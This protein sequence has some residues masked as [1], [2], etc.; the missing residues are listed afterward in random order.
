ML[1]YKA[2]VAAC[3]GIRGLMASVNILGRSI[4]GNSF[5]EGALV[6]VA[7]MVILSAPV[8]NGMLLCT[9]VNFAIY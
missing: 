9:L 7:V 5:L 8:S 6:C 2:V 3:S 1:S 4:N